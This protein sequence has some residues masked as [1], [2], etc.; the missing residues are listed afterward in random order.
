LG[1]EDGGGEGSI[2]EFILSTASLFSF[3]LREILQLVR[4]A[5]F[6]GIELMVT[7]REETQSTAYV[8]ELAAE[9]D[10][11]VRSIHAPFLFAAKKVWGD[12]QHKI[13]SSLDMAR[14]LGAGVVVVHLPYFWQWEYARWVRRNLNSCGGHGEAIVAVE[15]AMKVF[16]HRPLNLSLYNSL[17][18]MGHFDNLVFDTS[19]YAIA[20]IDI[21][22]AWEELGER[23]RHI[24]L[25][26]NYLKGFDDHALPFEGRLPLDRFL[27]VLHRDGFDGKVALELGPGPLEARLGRKRI[28]DNLRRS[29]DFCIANFA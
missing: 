26:N 10:I 20:G 29:L 23:V 9:F 8:K 7:R 22:E 3:E 1:E 6:R 19:H 16:I 15:N 4:E 12:P 28:V 11:A 24:H 18:E 5:G 2:A 14:E 21:F 17:R 27:R 13:A 25:S